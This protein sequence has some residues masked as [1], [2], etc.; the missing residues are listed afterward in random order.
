MTPATRRRGTALE[1][2]LLEAAWDELSEVGYAAL[3]MEGVAARARTSRAVLYR[4]LSGDKPL[5]AGYRLRLTVA[6]NAVSAGLR[7]FRMGDHTYRMND[8]DKF[9]GPKYE[10]MRPHELT[11]VGTGGMRSVRRR[12]ADLRHLQDAMGE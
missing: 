3:T 12:R 7:W 2:A 10:R 8:P 5:S 11:R 4:F 6:I 9:N 1:A